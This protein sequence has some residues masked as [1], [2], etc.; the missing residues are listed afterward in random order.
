[1]SLITI[2]GSGPS[3]IDYPFVTVATKKRSVPSDY[4]FCRFPFAYSLRQGETIPMMV[5][6]NRGGCEC[7]NCPQCKVSRYVVNSAYWDDYY[8]RFSK[9]KP[10]SGLCAVFAAVERWEPSTIG[11]IG[12]D[13]VL[14]QYTDWQHDSVAELRCIRSLVNVVDLRDGKKIRKAPNTP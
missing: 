6:Y 1:M 5:Y 10:S 4:L 9:K 14:G 3:A 13:W 2:A 8:S 12:F 11:L 7:K